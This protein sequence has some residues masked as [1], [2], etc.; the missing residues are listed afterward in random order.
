MRIDETYAVEIVDRES[1]VPLPEVERNGKVYVVARPGLEFKVK[2]SQHQST[3]ASAVVKPGLYYSVGRMSLAYLELDGVKMN[4]SKTLTESHPAVFDGFVEQKGDRAIKKSFCFSP[5]STSA[6]DM[7]MQ[8]VENPEQ[9]KPETKKFFLQPSLECTAGSAQKYSTKNWST[10]ETPDANDFHRMLVDA[11]RRQRA[12]GVAAAAAE[13]AAAANAEAE[14]IE[15]GKEDS[16]RNASRLKYKDRERR[17]AS[18]PAPASTSAFALTRVKSERRHSGAVDLSRDGAVPGDLVVHGRRVG[19]D[20]AAV[21]DLTRSSGST[22]K[23][24]K[25]PRVVISTL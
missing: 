3:R 25:K 5:F 9:I 18:A 6:P 12:A 21:C 20:E 24:V 10:V 8:E 14:L 2:I 7:G 4:H 13:A 17:R 11:E 23:V 16:A 15:E 1:G 19:R 22:W